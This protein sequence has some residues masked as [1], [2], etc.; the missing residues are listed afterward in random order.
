[1]L[2][3]AESWLLEMFG[4]IMGDFLRGDGVRRGMV[5]V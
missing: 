5:L 1:V 2:V 3:G 4:G